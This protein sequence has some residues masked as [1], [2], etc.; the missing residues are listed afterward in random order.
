MNRKRDI[1]LRTASFLA[2]FFL[3]ASVFNPILLPFDQ[4]TLWAARFRSFYE[5]PRNSIDVLYLGSSYVFSGVIPL[6][7]WKNQGYTGFVR[8][9]PFQSPLLSYYFLAESLHYQTP[10]IVVVEVSQIYKILDVDTN[11]GILRRGVDPM[12]FSLTKLRFIYDIV[13]LSDHQSI[14]SYLFPMFQYHYRWDELTW[15]D[16][17]G[18]DQKII[19]VYKGYPQIYLD[20][21]PFTI[22]IKQES[23]PDN[24]FEFNSASLRYYEKIINLCQ[25]NGIQLV[26]ITF[27]GIHWYPEQHQSVQDLADEHDVVYLDFSQEDA[28]KATGLDPE[29]DFLDG[30][31]L[32]TYG[33]QKMSFALGT[34]LHEMQVLQNKQND[35]KYQQWNLDLKTYENDLFMEINR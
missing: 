28:I 8:S 1:A 17:F 14:M 27:P 25:K 7:I 13:R 15:S 29:K 18:Q 9:N 5:Q 11:E 12:R 31:H 19:D 26:L 32:N 4:S 34:I 24:S 23:S 6:E 35:P 10:K 3:L 20:S 22:N 2:I 33:A 21:K 30:Q 16:I